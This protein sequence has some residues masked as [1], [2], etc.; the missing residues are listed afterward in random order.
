MG[1]KLEIRQI[2][3]FSTSTSFP[4]NSRTEFTKKNFFSRL[5]RPF[6]DFVRL[7]KFQILFG[8]NLDWVLP[9]KKLKKKS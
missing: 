6:L 8:C 9:L 7:K 1:I 4:K 5:S 2:F 3:K